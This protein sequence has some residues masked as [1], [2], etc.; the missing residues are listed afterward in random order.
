MIADSGADHVD[1]VQLC[2]RTALLMSMVSTSIGSNRCN[3]TGHSLRTLIHQPHCEPVP[4]VPLS[5][6][7]QLLVGFVQS[8]LA[9]VQNRVF[10]QILPC[11][12]SCRL[13]PICFNSLGSFEVQ[14]SAV[15]QTDLGFMTLAQKMD[16]Q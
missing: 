4:F 12:S 11:L 2:R 3:R 5:L 7:D 6:T 15:R 14:T 1:K 8:K 10:H 9:I 13:F 16:L